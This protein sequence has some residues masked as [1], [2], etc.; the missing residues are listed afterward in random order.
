MNLKG[1]LKESI[2]VITAL[3]IIKAVEISYINSAL[4]RNIAKTCLV[5]KDS[6]TYDILSKYAGKNPYYRFS[7]TYKI[8]MSIAAIFDKL[9]GRIHNEVKRWFSGSKAAENIVNAVKLTTDLKLYG[10]GILFMSIPIGSI[11]SLIILGGISF[12]NLAMC[13]GIFIFGLLL[14]ILACNSEALK[15]SLSIRAVSKFFDLIR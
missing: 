1:V 7:F 12:V 4:K 14:V 5:F 15:E 2:I 3:N 13:W 8:V 10:F 9:F 11:L 6:K